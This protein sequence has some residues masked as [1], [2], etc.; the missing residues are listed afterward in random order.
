LAGV[1]V[2]LRDGEVRVVLET[3]AVRISDFERY[4]TI[5]A[6]AVRKV[7]VKTDFFPLFADLQQSIL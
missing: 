7:S 6:Y 1:T 2:E 4:L 3:P 5:F